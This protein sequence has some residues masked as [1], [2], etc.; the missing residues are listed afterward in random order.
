MSNPID[1]LSKFKEIKTIDPKVKVKD[2]CIYLYPFYFNYSFV[3]NFICIFIFVYVLTKQN[4]PLLNLVCYISIGGFLIFIITVLKFYNTI[5]IDNTH[6]IIT[7]KPTK[8][9]K[10]FLQEKTILFNEIKDITSVS[11]F[12]STGFR[13]VNR[14]YYITLILKD[15]DEIKLIGSNKEEIASNIAEN[16]SQIL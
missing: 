11:N 2:N 7:I 5:V 14:R 3:T 8:F 16:L 4:D 9:Y 15:E 1:R 6:R 10:F 13:T 12:Y